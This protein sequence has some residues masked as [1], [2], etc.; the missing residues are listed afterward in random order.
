MNDAKCICCG[1]LLIFSLIVVIPY[2]QAS[3][4]D[5]RSLLVYG[6]YALSTGSVDPSPILIKTARLNPRSSRAFFLLGKS[7][8]IKNPGKV[9]V[10]LRSR[11]F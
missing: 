3:S 9:R 7:L 11:C 5:W 1:D 8:V 6:E 4:D 10:E 2:V